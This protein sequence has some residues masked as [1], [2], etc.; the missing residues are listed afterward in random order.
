M[1]DA[2]SAMIK[3]GGQAAAS[4]RLLDA[5]RSHAM[6][7]PTRTDERMSLGDLSLI[8]LSMGEQRIAASSPDHPK[9]RLEPNV[10]M[11]LRMKKWKH[12]EDDKNSYR[13]AVNEHAEQVVK[14][15]KSQMQQDKLRG[16][17]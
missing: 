9:D 14:F 15:M 17:F 6:P 16:Q 7:S 4:A 10:S 11:A 1:Q 8:A 13:K 2:V 3:S 12:T 5:I